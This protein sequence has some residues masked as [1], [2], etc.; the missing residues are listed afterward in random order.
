MRVPGCQR[1]LSG[2]RPWGFGPAWLVRS[3]TGRPAGSGYQWRM[4]SCDRAEASRQTRIESKGMTAII[5]PTHMSW[6]PNA[7]FCCTAL[8]YF[9]HS[10]WCM[11]GAS[12]HMC[13]KSQW[14]MHALVRTRH[15]SALSCRL[16]P[17]WGPCRMSSRPAGKYAGTWEVQCDK[18]Q[19]NS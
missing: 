3:L 2:P 10:C 9:T 14:P 19:T 13:C 16:E 1:W 12:S 6:L 5:R 7:G 8:Y 15:M 4:V 17:R 18:T 11:H